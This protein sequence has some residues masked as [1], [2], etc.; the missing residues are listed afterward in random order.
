MCGSPID[1]KFLDNNCHVRAVRGFVLQPAQGFLS[2]LSRQLASRSVGSQRTLGSCGLK[3]AA[4]YP[5]P[6]ATSSKVYGVVFFPRCVLRTAPMCGA[7][8]GVCRGGGMSEDGPVKNNV[9][10]RNP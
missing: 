7:F 8:L 4:W 5:E 9:M 2:Y 10:H 6:D 1:Q 3:H